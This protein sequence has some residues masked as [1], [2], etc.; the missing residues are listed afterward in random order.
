[1]LIC[2]CLAA[3]PVRAAGWLITL[4]TRRIDGRAMG[5]TWLVVTAALYGSAA[6]IS[7]WRL[8]G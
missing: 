3:R 6:G 7:V 5:P 2:P 1:M 4:A 8:L